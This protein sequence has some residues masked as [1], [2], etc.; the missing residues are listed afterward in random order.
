MVLSAKGGGVGRT[1]IDCVADS[2]LAAY[3]IVKP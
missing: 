1:V 3:T 2:S